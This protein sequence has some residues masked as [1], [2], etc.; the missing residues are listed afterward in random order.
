MVCI[1][2]SESV[3]KPEGTDG[4]K[5]VIGS[6]RRKWKVCTRPKK[7]FLFR[8]LINLTALF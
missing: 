7:S 1:S 3:Q 6:N 2:V 8:V 4:D 5:K